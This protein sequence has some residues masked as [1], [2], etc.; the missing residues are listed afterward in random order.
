VE[1]LKA[2]DGDS[3][4]LDGSDFGI[5]SVMDLFAEVYRRGTE[6]FIEE[7]SRIV[8]VAVGVGKGIE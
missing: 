7:S 3:E 6:M 8:A 5:V 4:V 1:S 2:K